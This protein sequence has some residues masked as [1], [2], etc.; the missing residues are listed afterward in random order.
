MAFAQTA[1]SQFGG[2]EK[3]VGF[4]S[5]LGVSGARGLE[6]ANSAD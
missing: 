2:V 5:F 3:A 1:K 6:T 4:V